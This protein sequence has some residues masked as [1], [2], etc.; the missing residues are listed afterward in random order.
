MHDWGMPAAAL[1]LLYLA[2]SGYVMW[3]WPKWQK[4]RRRRSN[5]TRSDA[6]GRPS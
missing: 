5:E 4:W 3:L 2:S 1:I 6:A